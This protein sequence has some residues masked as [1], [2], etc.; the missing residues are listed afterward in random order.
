MRDFE[1]ASSSE[2][3]KVIAVLE[4]AGLVSREFHLRKLLNNILEYLQRISI[5]SEV[6]LDS[7]GSPSFKTKLSASE[8]HK[9]D[10]KQR[11]NVGHDLDDLFD[12]LDRALEHEGYS[13]WILLDRLDVAF[14]EKDQLERNVLRA[15]FRCYRDLRGYRH[16]GLKIFLR[17][18]IWERITKGGMTEASHFVRKVTLAWSRDM[19]LNLMVKR[20][21]AS[22][23]VRQFMKVNNDQILSDLGMQEKFFYEVFPKT[24]GGRRASFDWVLERTSDATK[25]AMPREVIHF[26]NELR[27]A[28]IK[29]LMIGVKLSGKDGKLFSDDAFKEALPPV[30]K[31]RLEQTIYAEYPDKKNLIERLRNRPA[32]LDIR[33]LRSIWGKTTDQVLEAVDQLKDIGFLEVRGSG[34]DFRIPYLYR[35]ALGL[36]GSTYE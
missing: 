22:K 6:S 35:P 16:I 27:S 31:A 12:S 19:L 8:L 5:V 13:I 11:G 24:V 23:S 3:R 14:S 18:D 21:M 34:R 10:A 26:F 32:N 25:K 2:A 29:R 36:E 7:G 1:L 28:E 33:A 20:I 30:S 17:D 9:A 4:E 15:L